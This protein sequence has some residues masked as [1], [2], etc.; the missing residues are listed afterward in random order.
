MPECYNKIHIYKNL[1]RDKF[2]NGIEVE[3][4]KC[5]H[6]KSNRAKEK[7]IR[8]L[9]EKEMNKDS[10]I[11]FL[12]WTLD[13]KYTKE[14]GHYVGEDEKGQ[15][16]TLNKNMIRKIRDK[17]YSRLYRWSKKKFKDKKEEYYTK[18]YKYMIAGEYG[19]DGTERAHYHLI[20]LTFANHSKIRNEWLN[21]WKYGICDVEKDATIKSIFYTA[22][23]VA[24]KLG[25]KNDD[26]L[27]EPFL[28]MSRGLGKEWALKNNKDILSKGWIY[29]PSTK[30]ATRMKVPRYYIN[31]IIENEVWTEEEEINY[32][33]RIRKE[34]ERR[35]QEIWNRV[36]EY[37]NKRYENIYKDNIVA[38]NW[39]EGLYDYRG[40]YKN[41]YYNYTEKQT[42]FLR[43]R[44][45][46]HLKVMNR[47]KEH[48]KAFFWLKQKILKRGNKYG[49]YYRNNEKI[50][51]RQDYIY[52]NS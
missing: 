46:E 25:T 38:E 27:E 39:Y 44:Y 4:G 47:R 9:H 51:R 17:I 13:D 15:I 3:C 32:K 8:F 28:M 14:S 16:T 5:I 18:K 48:N 43:N 22:G 19:E 34:A 31:K 6:C 30:G 12:T 52:K 20:I 49:K 26:K 45:Y 40:D 35:T 10:K 41:E 2:P 23:Y 36:K 37:H 42:G 11:M 50:Q 7:A 29:R 21:E 33:E 1:D 24:K